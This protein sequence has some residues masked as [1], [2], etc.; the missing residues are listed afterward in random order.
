MVKTITQKRLEINYRTNF[1]VFDWIR[2]F[3]INDYRYWVQILAKF[4]ETKQSNLEKRLYHELLDTNVWRY[5]IYRERWLKY[6]HRAHSEA[7]FYFYFYVFTSN[8]ILVE[9][10]KKLKLCK[11]HIYFKLNNQ[12]QNV[13]YLNKSN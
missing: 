13:K 3:I 2:S 10:T 4:T 1:I 6:T 7:L 11:T 12:R 9:Q 8:L 5:N